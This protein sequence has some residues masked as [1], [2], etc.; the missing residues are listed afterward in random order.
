MALDTRVGNQGGGPGLGVEQEQQPRLIRGGVVPLLKQLLAQLIEADPIVKPVDGDQLGLDVIGLEGRQGLFNVAVGGPAQHL[1]L[2]E[3][4]SC[5]WLRRQVPHGQGHDRPGSS[6]QE[7]RRDQQGGQPTPGSDLV[8]LAKKKGHG[9]GR[10]GAFE[11]Q[12]DRT[13]TTSLT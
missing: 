8:P 6:Q 3:H 1:G 11:E 9:A 13:N 2:I 12:G 4:M 10:W 7:P 5:R